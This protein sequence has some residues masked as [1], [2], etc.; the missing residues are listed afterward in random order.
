[1]WPSSWPLGA[2]LVFAL[3]LSELVQYAAHS[4]MHRSQWL[5]PFHAVHHSPERLHLPSTFRNHPVDSALTVALPLVPIALA[6]GESNLLTW[7]GIAIGIHSMAQHSNID[8]AAGP[9]DQILSTSRLHRWHH[10]RRLGEGEANY[11]GT[12]IVWDT[13][14]KTRIDPADS[15]VAIPE[16]GLRGKA[17]FPRLYLGQ[18]MFPFR[19]LRGKIKRESLDGH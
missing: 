12:L 15:A 16:V 4:A 9:I 11:G 7:T 14:F 18:L 3:V 1:M 19:R 8:F 10:S 6:G 5:W 13:L 17:D 2:Q